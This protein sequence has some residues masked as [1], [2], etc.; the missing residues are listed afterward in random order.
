ML[1]GQ[2]RG[3]SWSLLAIR[4]TDMRLASIPANLG[5]TDLDWLLGKNVISHN[6][7]YI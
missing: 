2:G 1:S 7:C 6:I 4:T 5:K 3:L